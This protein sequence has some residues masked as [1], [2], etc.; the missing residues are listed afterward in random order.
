[1][2]LYTGPYAS[3]IANGVS[4]SVQVGGGSLSEK[5][6]AVHNHALMWNGTS[7]TL[8]DLHLAGFSDSWANAT[9]SGRQVGYGV[10][11]LTGND[12][13]STIKN[14]HALVWSGNAASVIDLHQF[15]PEG[16]YQSEATCIDPT[17]GVIGGK[18]M[19][20]EGRDWQPVI[21][22]PVLP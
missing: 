11:E 3:T 18:A 17:S 19:G 8:R 7:S 15:F 2:N 5:T 21:W 6:G 1:V 16:F 4:G 22:V 20:V 13:F 10:I 12:G 9:D 14:S